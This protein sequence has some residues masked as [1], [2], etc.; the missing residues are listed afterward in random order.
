MVLLR[1]LQPSFTAGELSPA[2]YA[3]TDLAKYQ[4]GL[5]TGLNIFIHPH[6][7]VSNRAGLE[8]CCAV[9][10]SASAVKL[11]D[12][13]FN[14]EQTYV[15]EFGDQTVRVIKDG[16]QVL[17]SAKTGTITAI[18]QASPGVVTIT[19]HPFA[20]GD[21][22]Y[23]ATIS[24]MVEL[25]GRNFRVANAT[26]N[27]FTLVDR[28]GTDVDTTSYGAYLSDGQAD[29][30]Y[31]IASPYPAAALENLTYVQEADV[32]YFCH[33]D[34][35]IRKLGRTGD[36]SWT[37]SQPDFTP[38]MTA[39][40]NVAAARASG[41]GS[42]QYRYVVSAIDEDTGEESLPSAEA[43]VTNNLLIAGYKNTISWDAVTG[44]SRYIV[45]KYDSGVFGYI[46]G[47]DGTTLIDENITADLA[48]T[49]QQAR[50]PFDGPGKYPRCATFFEQR[51]GFASTK[52]DPQAVW[53]SQSAN[54][55]NFGISSPAKASDAITFR[56]RARQVNQVRSMVPSRTL[57]LLTSGATWTVTG[58]AEEGYLTPSNPIIRPQLYRGTSTVQPLLVGNVM[59]FPLARGG[60]INDMSYQFT[61]D[62][63]VDNDLTVLSRHLFDNKEVKAWGYAQAPWSMVWV[64]MNDGS[65]L[66]MT[67]LRKHEIWGWTRHET[68]GFV[69]DVTVIDEDDEDVP[70]FLVRRTINGQSKRY[71][72]RL[73]SRAFTDVEDAFFVDS[74]LTYDGTPADELS[75][76]E[77]L[78]GEPVVALAD[79]N[80]VQNLTVTGGLITL[81]YEAGKI[82]VG[83][84][85]IADIE[86]LPLDI[87]P[88]QGIGT[89][90]GRLRTVPDIHMRVE[91]SR[92]LFVGPDFDNLN[93]WKQRQ[94]EHYGEPIDLYTGLMRIAPEPVWDDEGTLCVRQSY[95]LPMTVLSIM[96]D[97]VSG[98]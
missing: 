48:D 61:E 10:D 93:E 15:L 57:L 21:E 95:P 63:Y 26:A 42:T 79:G 30:V 70:Y 98:G 13:Q 44:A 5:K 19:G 85:M 94:T 11:V 69:E 96:P 49:P 41:S 64:V 90:Q 20:D 38:D 92:G 7:G 25:N 8:F 40:V 67:Y 32:M 91:N 9:A 86:T 31:Q 75:G 24:G 72:E 52:E 84:Q 2:L 37:F 18:S 83:R 43:S 78:E 68:G 47:A 36:D 6:G 55:E 73:H 12:F 65:L 74:G 23:L 50:N 46:G 35:A 45:Y 77:H 71:I 16:A 29:A 54:Y 59:L 87:G 34:F 53:F 80:V 97:L 60:I 51:L 56:L 39:P 81:P 28:W 1:T 3:R 76:L 88:V 89:I 27:S 14:T 22:I 66:S 4:T 62:G 58:G 82:H 17:D 33:E